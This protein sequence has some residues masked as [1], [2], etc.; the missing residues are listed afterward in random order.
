MQPVKLHAIREDEVIR[1]GDRYTI[2]DPNYNCNDPDPDTTDDYIRGTLS[3]TFNGH[4]LAHCRLNLSMVDGIRVWRD[5]PNDTPPNVP[6]LVLRRLGEDEYIRPGDLYT[7]EDP[8]DDILAPHSTNGVLHAKCNNMRLSDCRAGTMA[9]G[10]VVWRP[11]YDYEPIDYKAKYEAP[12]RGM[13][14]L[15]A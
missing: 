6:D 2:V 3:S 11:L 10:L 13:R 15:V 5:D 1:Q 4:T 14:D 12:L 9:P 8:G 7:H